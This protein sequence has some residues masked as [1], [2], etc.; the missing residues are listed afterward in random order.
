MILQPGPHWLLNH[1]SN[2]SAQRQRGMQR[3]VSSH[4][5]SA[6][7]GFLISRTPIGCQL[8]WETCLTSHP[9]LQ[10][11]VDIGHSSQDRMPWARSVSDNVKCLTLILSSRPFKTHFFNG[12]KDREACALCPTSTLPSVGENS[13]Y[14]SRDLGPDSSAW[15]LKLNFP[16]LIKLNSHWTHS[17]NSTWGRTELYVE[18]VQTTVPFSGVR[19]C[20]VLGEIPFGKQRQPMV[21]VSWVSIISIMQPESSRSYK[22]LES[23][24]SEEEND[25]W[26]LRDHL[27]GSKTSFLY[28]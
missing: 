23:F 25:S 28:V 14:C 7:W 9:A 8:A 17:F 19:V 10:L 13:K 3:P 15:K 24:L 21:L 26:I 5:T 1:C 18:W 20:N 22:V 27:G 11:R 16:V 6:S 12:R 4:P 2:N